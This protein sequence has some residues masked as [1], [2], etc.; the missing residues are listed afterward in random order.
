MFD[1]YSLFLYVSEAMESILVK[2]R[3]FNKKT[4]TQKMILKAKKL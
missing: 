3:V 4:F 1:F 2:G